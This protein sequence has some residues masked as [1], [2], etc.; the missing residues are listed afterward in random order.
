MK[1]SLAQAVRFV[2]VSTLL[3][4]NSG[5]MSNAMQVGMEVG[6]SQ[7]ETPTLEAQA[8]RVVVATG[9]VRINHVMATQMPL[10]GDAQWPAEMV[11]EMTKKQEKLIDHWLDD[12]PYFATKSYTD[13]VQKQ[14]LGGLFNVQVSPLTYVAIRKLVVLYG[15]DESKAPNLFDYSPSF[16]NFLAFKGGNIQLK[17]I[18]AVK[19]DSYPT[20]GDAVHAL[21]PDTF[22]EDLRSQKA[23]MQDVEDDVL[24][25]EKEK[26]II[27]AK[28]DAAALLKNS[29]IKTQDVALSAAKK[30][31][32]E[33]ELS[34]LNTQITQKNAVYEERKDVYFATLDSARR[35]LEKDIHLSDEQIALAKNA[36]LVSGL[37]KQGAIQAGA[38]YAAALTNLS[39]KPIV[40]N[41]PKEL[42]TLVVGTAK[43][44]HNKKGL[45]SARYQRLIENGL[46]LIPSIGMGSYYAV[47]QSNLASKY[48]DITQVIVTAAE[49][50]AKQQSAK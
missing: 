40:Q 22:K 50:Q 41:F 24:S 12:D 19:A 21:L 3:L 11:K 48:E 14:A 49:A 27:Q 43:V 29:G 38:L 15:E 17:T 23:D 36:H 33:Q 16:D 46:M 9:V 42:Q 10:S 25:L 13:D 28:L 20:L 18:E 26:A 31:A 35:V 39:V 2:S 4:L 8:N 32:L 47:V 1:L 7:L 37:I 44:P 45:I 6:V 34:E 30:S 5:C